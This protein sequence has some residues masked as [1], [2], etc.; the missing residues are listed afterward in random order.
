MTTATVRSEHLVLSLLL[1]E[2]VTVSG[3]APLYNHLTEEYVKVSV[4][5]V[6]VNYK[7]ATDQALTKV[8]SSGT[9]Y[10]SSDIDYTVKVG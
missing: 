10:T 9:A 3:T 8:V 6:C 2:P 5:P 1:T 4:A 7:V